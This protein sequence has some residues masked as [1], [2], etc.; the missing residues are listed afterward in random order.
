MGKEEN[1]KG[2]TKATQFGNGQPTNKGGTKKGKRISTILKELLQGDAKR[3]SKNEDY[4]KLNTNTAIAIELIAMVFHKD[5]HPKDR[6][7][8]IREI[9]DRVEGKPKQNLFDFDAS[10]IKPI[11]YRRATKE[12]MEQE[13]NKN[14]LSNSNYS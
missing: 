6:L 7:N 8:A 4:N 11:T 10:E 13:K 12:D 5:S 3:F 1:F 14:K 2:N 9:L